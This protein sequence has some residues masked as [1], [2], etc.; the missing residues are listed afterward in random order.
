MHNFTYDF[1]I[2][3]ICIWCRTHKLLLK[4]LCLYILLNFYNFMRERKRERES[5]QVHVRG[6][7]FTVLGCHF[8]PS[9]I[10]YWN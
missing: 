1:N 6:N 3:A 5:A 4:F 8:S 9:N 2:Q 7:Q 10:G